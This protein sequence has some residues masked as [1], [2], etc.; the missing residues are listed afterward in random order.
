MWTQ[1][2]AEFVIDTKLSDVPQEA[3]DG[4]RNALI[5]SIGCALAGT[6]E[7]I[8]RIVVSFLRAQ[9]GNAADRWFGE[10]A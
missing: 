9:G 10:S 1:K 7:E 2:L 4:A 5:D 6:Q 8:C 3:L